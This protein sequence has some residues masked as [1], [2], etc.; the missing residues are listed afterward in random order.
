MKPA[1]DKLFILEKVRD[2]ALTAKVRAALK[3]VPAR[4]ISSPEAAYQEV[5]TKPD[6]VAAGKKVL[7]ITENQGRF[8]KPC[9]GTKHYT[10]CGYHILHVGSYCPMDCTYCVLQTY[11]HP[12]L[13]QLFANQDAL[14]TEL[15]GL[16]TAWPRVRRL[17]T[18]E[19][20]D[21]LV[22]EPLWDLTPRL[23]EWFGN[24]DR[25]VLELKTK[26]VNISGLKGLAHGGKTI[27][28]WSVNTPRI[29]REHE[30]GAAPLAARLSAAAACAEAGYA[31]A[32]HFDP[33]VPYEA[34]EQEYRKVVRQIFAAVDPDRVAWISLG[35][36]RYPPS[37]GEVMERRRPGLTLGEMIPGLDNKM[38]AF[39]PIRMALS[40][41]VAQ[42][43]RTLAP[44]VCAYFCMEDR[45]V[46]EKCMGFW[47]G[48]EG[49]SRLLDKS[50]ARVCGI[51]IS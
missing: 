30:K 27:L 11:F 5:L 50:A 42:E 15:E 6:P 41:A 31:L 12:P 17:G 35:T 4:E 36:L 33:L 24:Q 43:I 39:K 8:I 44:G 16:S 10:C 7:L 51:R 23:V 22:W 25:A 47:P 32:F 40:R 37:L 9:P 1:I 3:G 38:R 46:W 13:L 2:S 21:S 49:L 14:F 20:T 28:S 48:E 29:I 34:A 26:T 18:G 45:Q 19:F